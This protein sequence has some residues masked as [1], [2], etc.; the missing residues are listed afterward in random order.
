MEQA[1]KAISQLMISQLLI[2]Q[3]HVQSS[4][5]QLNLGDVTLNLISADGDNRGQITLTGREIV[6]IQAP[7]ERDQVLI[8]LQIQVSVVN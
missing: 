2:T 1:T 3:D 4:Q 8:I 7:Q 5:L 6:D